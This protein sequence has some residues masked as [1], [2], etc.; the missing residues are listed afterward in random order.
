[1][2]RCSVLQAKPRNHAAF[3]PNPQA[4]HHTEKAI[5]LD[6]GRHH[7]CF[8]SPGRSNSRD[9]TAYRLDLS[10]PRFGEGLC[11][12]LV[13]GC[14]SAK[15]ADG[16]SDPIVSAKRYGYAARRQRLTIARAYAGSPAGVIRHPANVCIGRSAGTL[17]RSTDGRTI[18][19]PRPEFTKKKVATSSLEE[20]WRQR[21]WRAES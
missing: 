9:K 12:A 5:L 19:R 16:I 18:I 15:F 6:H 1:M 3:G 21:V 2:K 10:Q 20:A 7:N 8:P 17:K 13:F 4:L 14:S 11:E